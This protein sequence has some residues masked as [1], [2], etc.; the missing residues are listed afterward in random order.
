MF[1][2]PGPQFDAEPE[3]GRG[4]VKPEGQDVGRV[5][6]QNSIL[7]RFQIKTWSKLIW[8]HSASFFFQ[9]YCN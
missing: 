8:F 9:V 5:D 2:R 3:G 1:S 6:L 4:A 7:A